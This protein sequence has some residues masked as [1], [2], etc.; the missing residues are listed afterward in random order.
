M[1]LANLHKG[2][3]TFLL[4]NRTRTQIDLKVKT[5]L[6]VSEVVQGHFLYSGL[7]DFDRNVFK[8]MYYMYNSNQIITV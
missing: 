6:R 7:V 4:A 1:L 5:I 3:C 8:N 2:A